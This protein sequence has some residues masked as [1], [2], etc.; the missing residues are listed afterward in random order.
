MIHDTILA[1]VKQKGESWL[2]KY[3]QRD[4]C[5]CLK[6]RS[7]APIFTCKTNNNKKK[8]VLKHVSRTCEPHRFTPAVPYLK[9]LALL[10]FKRRHRL[11]EGLEVGALQSH[12]P[13]TPAQLGI[14]TPPFLY[15]KGLVEVCEGNQ[16]PL[17]PR[18][19]SAL[20]P[21]LPRRGRSDS[22]LREKPGI[23]LPG[24]NSA[25]WYPQGHGTAQPQR[26][27]LVPMLRSCT[28]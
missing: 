18:L 9:A 17:H 19:G 6:D 25:L 12:S 16:S 13:R 14:F 24:G 10:I 22:C 11:P 21:L 15:L 7:N 1:P 28:D 3:R 26:A 2:W 27:R 23:R 4:G 8:A 20:S 5:L